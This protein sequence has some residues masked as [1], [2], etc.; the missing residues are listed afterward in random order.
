MENKRNNP[1]EIEGWGI[2]AD[3]QND[4]TFPI[5]NRSK[6]DHQGKNWERPE[7]QPQTV[8]L[9]QSI[10][11]PSLSAVF[12]TSMA[13][14][15]L[16]GMIRRKA[17]EFSESHLGH[18][19]MLVLADKINVIE[20]IADDVKQGHFPNFFAEKGLGAEWK[21]NRKEFTKKVVTTA[22]IATTA[23]TLIALLSRK[24]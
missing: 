22:V 1:M 8:E 5:R 4:P 21:Y 15:G 12:G 9:L 16:S 23:I 6:E 18:W 14:S 10:E 24:K 11:R 19:F 7:Q 17:F 3:Q 20:G 13:P 2:D